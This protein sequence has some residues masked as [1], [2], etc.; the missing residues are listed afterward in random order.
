MRTTTKKIL[1]R[2]ILLLIGIIGISIITYV[3]TFPYNHFID[4]KAQHAKQSIEHLTDSLSSLQVNLTKLDSNRI[5]LFLN[6]KDAFSKSAKYEF[7]DDYKEFKTRVDYLNS[8][9]S[10]DELYKSR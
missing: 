5:A 8:V 1:A 7:Y 9:D 6:L 2:E 10:L 4:S 3:L